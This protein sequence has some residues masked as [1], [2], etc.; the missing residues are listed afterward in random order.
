MFVGG[1]PLR[2]SLALPC[3]FK[4]QKVYL[5]LI[6]LICPVSWL[7]AVLCIMAELCFTT[8]ADGNINACGI[9]Q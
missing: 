1:Y 8:M 5:L 9:W 3:G 6:L 7:E 4:Q 2:T